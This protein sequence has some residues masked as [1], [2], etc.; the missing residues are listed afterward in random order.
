MAT[1]FANRPRRSVLGPLLAC[2]RGQRHVHQ[3][4]D[5]ATA[6]VAVHMEGEP[7]QI[8]DQG[9]RKTETH[10]GLQGRFPRECPRRCQDGA[11]SARRAFSLCWPEGRRLIS[12]LAVCLRS[13]SC[14]RLSRTASTRTRSGPPQPTPATPGVAYRPEPES[15]G[16][17]A[18]VLVMVPTAVE[19]ERY[20]T[21]EGDCPIFSLT[22]ATPQG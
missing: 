19:T 1:A 16:L 17:G 14:V 15:P 3:A 13:A 18:R 5:D 21:R 8:A 12:F 4:V 22:I 2:R 9:W 20:P 11:G 6:E 7:E 10:A